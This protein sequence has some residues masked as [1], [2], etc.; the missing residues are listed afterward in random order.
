MKED[1]I[2]KEVPEASEQPSGSTKMSSHAGLPHKHSG[3]KMPHE[4]FHDKMN[5]K[6]CC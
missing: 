1:K 4:H 5:S 6:L 2:P 3:D